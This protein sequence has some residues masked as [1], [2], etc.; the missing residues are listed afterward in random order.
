[1]DWVRLVEV[2]VAAAVAIG[3]IRARLERFMTQLDLLENKVDDVRNR[4][5]KLEIQ[6]A[7]LRGKEEAD[8]SGI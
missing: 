5:R 4:L 6:Q 2:V 3:Y 7:Y 1:M 8:E